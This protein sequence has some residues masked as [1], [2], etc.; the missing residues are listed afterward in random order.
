MHTLSNSYSRLLK[1]RQVSSFSLR[2][3]TCLK[4]LW[5]PC[6]TH[7][8]THWAPVKS[9]EMV[10]DGTNVECVIWRLQWEEIISSY[11]DHSFFPADTWTSPPRQSTLTLDVFHLK[12]SCF[13]GVH[14]EGLHSLSPL[15]PP[16]TPKHQYVDFLPHCPPW[17]PCLLSSKQLHLQTP[18]SKRRHANVQPTFRSQAKCL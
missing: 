14:T 2:W 8:H 5:R 6:F 7:L 11:M 4:R 17:Q 3:Q 10:S 12:T 13:C 9:S 15:H 18:Q 16:K 1:R